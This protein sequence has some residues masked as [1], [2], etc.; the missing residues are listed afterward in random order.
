M[1][2]DEPGTALPVRWIIRRRDDVVT[3][4]P[5]SV[6]NTYGLLPCN[7]RKAR[8]SGPCSGCTLSIPPLALFTCNLPFLRSTCDQRKLQSSCARNPCRYANRI[9][10]ASLAPFHPRLRTASISRST[11]FSVRYSRTR[12]SAVGV[13]FGSLLLALYQS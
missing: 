13:V 10:A 4:V 2:A 8:N 1:Y 9:A 12:S 6:T 11:S 7:G 5:A 3:G